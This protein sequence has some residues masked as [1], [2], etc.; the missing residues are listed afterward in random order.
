M[1]LLIVSHLYPYPGVD[2]H[3]FVH[4]QAVALHELGLDVRVVSPTPYVPKVLRLT[5]RLRRRG[6]KPPRALRDGIVADYPRFLQPPRHILF[7]RVGDLAYRRV[8]ALPWITPGAFDLIHA[9]QALPDGAVAARLS[10]DLGIPFVVTVHGADVHVSLRKGGRVAA[11]TRAV[12]G[13]ADAVIAVSPTL[14]RKLSA[15]VASEKLHVAENGGPG[16]TSPADPADPLGGRRFVL[17]AGRLV[18]GKGHEDVMR[19]A[20]RLRAAFPDVHYVIA[21]EGPLG[22]RLMTLRAG[23]GLDDRVHFVGRVEHGRLLQLMSG[24][25]LLALPSAPEGFGLVH[26][27]AMTQGTPVIG[28]L[29]QG[30][31]DYI[32]PGVSGYLVPPGDLDALTT[33][34]ASVLADPVAAA[35]VGEAGRT[36]AE[37]FTWAR[38][39]RLVN[40]VYQQVIAGSSRGG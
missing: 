7:D 12:L 2:R 28:C 14:A 24:A 16:G 31:A 9:H 1:R 4:D 36:V 33:V 18:P 38:T 32:Q 8:R 25:A 13:E 6:G 21:G 26:L 23:L 17:L 39:A 19:A 11:R 37:G 22:G 29:G 35:V 5:E 15:F 3:K 10:R 27:E 40:E 20:A 30:P 34:L